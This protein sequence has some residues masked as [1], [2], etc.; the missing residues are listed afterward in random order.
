M[1]SG[2]ALTFNSPIRL[3]EICPPKLFYEEYVVRV[4][5]VASESLQ[6]HGI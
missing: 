6:P 2:S 1:N 3:P 5:S 4:C